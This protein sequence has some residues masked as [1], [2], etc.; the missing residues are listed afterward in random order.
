MDPFDVTVDGVGAAAGEVVGLGEVFVE[1]A[2]TEVGIVPRDV[3]AFSP[4]LWECCSF[5][6]VEEIH[7]GLFSN[8][9]RFP[10]Q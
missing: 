5:A 6:E 10:F 7:F 8:C 2:P 1:H 4:R 9:L 3:V